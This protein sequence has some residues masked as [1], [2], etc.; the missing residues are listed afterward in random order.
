MIKRVFSAKAN[1]DI[2]KLISKIPK[3]K[4][5]SGPIFGYFFLENGKNVIHVS[6]LLDKTKA[7]NQ[8]YTYFEFRKTPRTIK[9]TEK[10]C[11]YKSSFIGS[12]HTHPQME[13]FPSDMDRKTFRDIQKER[14]IIATYFIIFNE[15]KRYELILKNNGNKEEIDYEITKN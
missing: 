11:S 5:R 6:R 15:A 9:R 1:E 12:W 4:E 3:G 7:S 8:T 13:V 14:K 2:K 10:E